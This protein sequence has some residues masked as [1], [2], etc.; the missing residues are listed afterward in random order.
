MK[1]VQSLNHNSPIEVASTAFFIVRLGHD[2]WY[3]NQTQY[4][5]LNLTKWPVSQCLGYHSLF[6]R[7]Q[8]TIV[9]TLFSSQVLDDD[10]YG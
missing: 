9:S 4:S 2:N 10:S 1:G 5:L 8:A 7:F 3:S 6:V